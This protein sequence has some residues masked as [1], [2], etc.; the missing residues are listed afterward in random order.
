MRQMSREW[1]LCGLLLLAGCAAPRPA[2]T[3]P[4]PLSPDARAAMQMRYYA[5]PVDVVFAATIA[6][7][8]DLQWELDTIDK[9][10]GILRAVTAR[11]FEP[12][13]P[14]EETMTDFSLRR[15]TFEARATARDQWARWEEMLIHIEPWREGRVRERIVMTR[16][17]SL[18]ALTY[19]TR[20]GGGFMRRGQDVWV[21]APPRED[22][23]EVIFPEVYDDVF[24]RIEAAVARRLAPPSAPGEGP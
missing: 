10:S 4:A 3:P 11:R 19:H 8:Q 14:S 2:E 16:R 18:P 6:V 20:Q 21:N 24:D 5:A 23:V 7:L 15:R 12:L 13:S 22:A 9:A 1:I 17:G